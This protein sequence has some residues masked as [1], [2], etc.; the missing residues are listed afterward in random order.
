MKIEYVNIVSAKENHW[1]KYFE[2]YKNQG[3]PVEE[4]KHQN[5]T[6]FRQSKLEQSQKSESDNFIFYD[7]DSCKA[8]IFLFGIDIKNKTLDVKINF[9]EDKADENLITVIIEFLNRLLKN[10]EG[11]SLIISSSQKAVLLLQ[12]KLHTF[13]NKV[14]HISRLYRTDID[15]N[16]LNE[17]YEKLKQN[18]SGFKIRKFI[19]YGDCSLSD[20]KIFLDELQP[21]FESISEGGIVKVT[22]ED[23]QKHRD[24]LIKERRERISYL[25]YDSNKELIAATNFEPRSD[26]IF[27]SL[28]GVVKKFREKKIAE[29][30]KTFSI[31]DLLQSKQ[32]FE[33]LQTRMNSK[34]TAIN[35]L[36]A[37]L[38]F[39]IHETS[40]E[41]ILK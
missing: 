5:V 17:S 9:N 23:L 13:E 22:L 16:F 36:N 39:K 26:V 3:I 21:D 32:D 33:Y 1:E 10:K 20:Y 27:T 4:L 35:S 37:R 29:Y 31:L 25:M 8:N 18:F 6:D 40:Y 14:Y 19:N 41:F 7:D 15:K 28:T 30:L 11:Y 24:I 12:E 2:F 34:N 38:G